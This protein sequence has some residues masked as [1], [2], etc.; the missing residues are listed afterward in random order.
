MPDENPTPALWPSA[1]QAIMAG[2]SPAIPGPAE[3]PVST[4]SAHIVTGMVRLAEGLGYALPWANL[5]DAC[6][7]LVSRAEVRRAV[8]DLI[9]RRVVEATASG[10][11]LALCDA[12]GAGEC[13]GSGTCPSRAHQHGCLSDRDGSACE[14]PEDHDA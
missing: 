8:D 7:G 5:L 12:P 14:Y 13:D 1:H 3:H 2:Q 9:D 11:R 6:A 10:L 4:E